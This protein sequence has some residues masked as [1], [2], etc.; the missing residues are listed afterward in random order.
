MSTNVAAR[1]RKKKWQTAWQRPFHQESLPTSNS[2]APHHDTPTRVKL[3]DRRA[4]Y[5]AEGV[6]K[7][8]RE[9]FQELRIPERSG[10]RIL[11]S[12]R[13]RRLQHSDQ[14][15]TRGRSSQITKRALR[16][17]EWLITRHG[18]DGRLLQWSDL[19]TELQDMD[20]QMSIRSI[21][22]WLGSI[23]FH[24]CIAC[25]RSKLF[26]Y[27]CQCSNFYTGFISPRHAQRRIEYARIML[28]RYPRPED[29]HRVRFSDE[30]HFGYGPESRPRILRRSWEKS[31]SDCI[32]ERR[33]PSEKDQKKTAC[34]GCYWIWL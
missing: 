13:E 16:H 9:L 8:S 32:I 2:M 23:D 17:L 14:H 3:L 4:R 29:W 27:F 25:T 7:S 5:D 31:C 10:Y 6:R 24:R 18:K 22:N 1:P 30:V 28:D 26:L 33:D 20:I 15:D 34:M 19:R 12:Q 21:Q 11:A